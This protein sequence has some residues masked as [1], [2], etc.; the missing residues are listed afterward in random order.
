[1]LSLLFAAPYDAPHL[2]AKA[3]NATCV[4]LTWEAPKDPNGVI[5]Q[6]YVYNVT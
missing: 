4:D 1:M 2:E 3:A 6:Y 5:L